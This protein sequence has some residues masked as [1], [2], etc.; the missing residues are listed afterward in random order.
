MS[1]DPEIK[2]RNETCTVSCHEKS[3]MPLKHTKHR[4]YSAHFHVAD[5][6]PSCATRVRASYLRLDAMSGSENVLLF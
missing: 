4:A 6:M 3:T 2:S 1:S 5:Y